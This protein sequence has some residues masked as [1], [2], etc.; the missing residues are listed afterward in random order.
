[1]EANVKQYVVMATR[2]FDHSG[3]ARKAGQIFQM[4]EPDYAVW[5]GFVKIVNRDLLPVKRVS[6]PATKRTYTKKG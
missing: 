4:S 1:M 5:G 6:K 2:D 3:E